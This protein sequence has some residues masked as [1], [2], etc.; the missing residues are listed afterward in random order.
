MQR[1]T[2]WIVI[3]AMVY[4]ALTLL[5][6]WRTAQQDE[7]TPAD[8][9]VVLGAAQWRGRPSPVF[10]ARL[11]HA[12]H[13]YQAGYAP[14]LITT[15]GHGP[16]P[17]F[18]EGGVG[19]AYAQAMGVPAEAL[20]SEQVGGTTHESMIE[21]A[22]LARTHGL[23]RIIV[24]SDPFH[25]ARIETIARGLG[26]EAFG[27]PTRTSPISRRPFLEFNHFLRE[28]LS[29]TIYRFGWLANAA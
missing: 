14:L 15:G 3:G 10:R 4:G 21:V 9:I 27:S 8:A 25:I 24:V 17:Q 22:A 1:F 23:R 2:R 29:L 28:V 19:A 16:D 7:A 5:Q 12:I 26:L 6:V 11:N 18:T 20:L 13:L